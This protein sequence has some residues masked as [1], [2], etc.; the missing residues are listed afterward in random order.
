[1]SRTYRFMAHGAFFR[2]E[3]RATRERWMVRVFRNGR[4]IVDTEGPLGALDD[5][6]L[7][8]AFDDV[9]RQAEQ[10]IWETGATRQR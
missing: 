6:A 10:G 2:A 8:T 3:A 4:F 9:R 5:R 1:M 7:A